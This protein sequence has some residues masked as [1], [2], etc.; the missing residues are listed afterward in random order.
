MLPLEL[1]EQQA[2]MI[3]FERDEPFDTTWSVRNVAYPGHPHTCSVGGF[4]H[5]RDLHAVLR[6]YREAEIVRTAYRARPLTDQVD[7]WL[8]TTVP[9]DMPGTALLSVG[10]VL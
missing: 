8:L 9:T 6:Q 10:D 2:R 3:Y 4:W 1:I 7:I 5:D